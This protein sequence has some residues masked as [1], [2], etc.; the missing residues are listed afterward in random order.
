MANS[1]LTLDQLDTVNGGT[2]RK[3]IILYQTGF[4]RA[5][6]NIDFVEVVQESSEL[7]HDA[8]ND[9]MVKRNDQLLYLRAI[10]KALSKI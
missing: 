9:V 1:E 6:S 10:V 5:L 4:M 8:Y 7:F 3:D 2:Y